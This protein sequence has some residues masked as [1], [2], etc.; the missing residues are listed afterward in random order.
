MII[1]MLRFRFRDGTLREEEAR[2]LAAIRRTATMESVSFS[3]VGQDLG[4][5]ADG[6]THAYCVGIADLPALQRYFD[7]PIHREGDFVF[8]PLLAKLSRTALSDDMAPGLGAEIAAMFQ[9]HMARD[10]E[11]ARLLAQIPDAN[12]RT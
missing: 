9:R 5:P 8:I 3:A 1:N 7:N 2:A 11:W 4:D 12:I 10:P 6:F